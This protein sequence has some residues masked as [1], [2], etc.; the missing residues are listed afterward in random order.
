MWG[1]VESGKLASFH[2]WYDK[3]A[4]FLDELDRRI[5]TMAGILAAH[6]TQ[7]PV[8]TEN[9]CCV[10]RSLELC[11]ADL[12]SWSYFWRCGVC[13]CFHGLTLAAPSGRCTLNAVLYVSGVLPRQH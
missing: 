12:F 11:F 10:P 2:L 1:V 5:D 3:D 8:S 6:S 13:A 9:G 7:N 4:A